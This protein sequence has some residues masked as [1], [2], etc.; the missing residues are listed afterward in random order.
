MILRRI[1]EHVNA[2]H[3]TAIVIDFVIVVVGVFIGIQVSNWNED[4]ATDREAAVFAERLK[5]DLRVEAWTYELNVSYY[6][7]V[8]ANARRV[9]NVLSGRS[10]LPDEALLVAAYRATQY[11][12]TN[13]RRTTCWLCWLCRLCTGRSQRIGLP[14]GR[15]IGRGRRGR[16]TDRSQ[17]RNHRGRHRLGHRRRS[18]RT[19]R[20]SSRGRGGRGR[21]GRGL[22]R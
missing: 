14:A 1:I 5:A 7:Q 2:Q 13:R 6:G 4:R 19:P 22:A 11:N 17:R 15:F 18:V 12:S 20:R 16:S 21:P 3:W 8:L 10:E 9:D